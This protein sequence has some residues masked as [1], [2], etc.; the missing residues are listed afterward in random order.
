MAFSTGTYGNLA[1]TVEDFWRK[2][3]IVKVKVPAASATLVNALALATFIDTHSTAKIVG[4]S[5]NVETTGDTATSG[6]KYDRVFQ[7][8]HFLFEENDGS[9]RRFSLPAPVETDVS[10]KQEPTADAAGLVKTL[11]GTLG[12]SIA[13]Y[14]GGGISSR[15]PNKDARDTEITE[16]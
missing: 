4:Y 12:L 11:L 13:E 5:A 2:S 10:D 16:E 3:G 14:N 7:R 9:S 1:V 8:L 15:L 6:T